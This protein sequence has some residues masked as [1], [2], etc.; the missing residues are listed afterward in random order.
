M[1]IQP[2]RLVHKIMKGAFKM[3]EIYTKP[4]A[5]VEIFEELDVLTVSGISGG[6]DD[7]RDPIELP[8]L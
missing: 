4:Q 3:K 7:K 1:A 5:D 2:K 6:D 8:D